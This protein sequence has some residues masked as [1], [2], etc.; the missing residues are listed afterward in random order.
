MSSLENAW[1]EAAE[2]AADDAAV[3]NR[4]DALDLA[5]ALIKLSRSSK[6]WSEPALA[7][8]LVS[9]SSSISLRVQRLLEWRTAGRR[10]QR[11][12]P[13]TL[14]VLS[15][16]IVGIASN[17]GATLALTHRLTEILVP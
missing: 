7:S 12:W 3:T 17:Y 16:M 4:Q 1:R 13:W 14:L 10:L 2:L 6:Q 8:G 5:A 15:I 9:G 11:T